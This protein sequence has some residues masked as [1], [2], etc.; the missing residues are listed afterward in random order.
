MEKI[1]IVP[2]IITFFL[3]IFFIPLWIKKMKQQGLLWEDMNKHNR[4]KNVAS[5]GGVVVTL[6]FIL[7][8]LSY[9][10]IKTFI[11]KTNTTTVEIF[12]ML[13]T[14]LL[15]L[16]IGFIDDVFGWIKGGLSTRFRIFL[17]IFASIPLV[18]IN[19][20]ESIIFGIP[21]GLLYPLVAIPIGVVGASSTYNFLAGFNGLE[22]S[23]GIIILSGLAITT[24]LNKNSWLSLICLIMICS[25]LAFYIFN[26]CPAK[27]FPGNTLTYPVGALIATIAI[28]GNI[29]KI[30]VFFFIPYIIETGLKVK[31]KLKKYSFGIPN[32]DNS[33][34]LPY[35]RIYGLTHLSIFILKKFKENVYEKDVVFLINLFQIIII[36]IGFMLFFWGIF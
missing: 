27:I 9:I 36:L 31:G 20:G 23:Q 11:L 17:L 35:K 14:I 19:A 33:L 18:V 22:T 21:V 29:E 28:L 2:F 4:P 6:A 5:S 32:E 34:E 3:V 10:A 30:A 12:A 8:V 7:G 15:A 24:Y 1:L 25:L 16:M 13:T 26:K